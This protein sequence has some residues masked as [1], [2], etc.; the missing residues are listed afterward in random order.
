VNYYPHHIGDFNNATRHLT[1]VERALYREL[2]ELYYDTE[3]PLPADDF[4]WICKKVLASSQDDRDAVK[5]ILREFFTLDGDFY[6]HA[7]CDREIIVYR[8][9]HDAA[10]KAGLASAASRANGKSTSVQRSLNRRATNQEPITNNQE[11]ESRGKQ[12]SR[13]SR[14]PPDWQPSE[15][16]KAWACKER[17]DLEIAQVSAKFRD[18]WAGVPGSKGCKL[19]WEATFRNFIRTEKPGTKPKEIDIEALTKRLEEQERAS[20][21]N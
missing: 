18:Y 10:I 17:P 3:S 9:K 6:R 8:A 1:R 2:I 15:I 21:G 7:R 14:L 4:E 20:A 19:D 11:P 13:G 16:L 5:A 12:R